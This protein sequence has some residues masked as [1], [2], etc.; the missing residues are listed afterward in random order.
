M[1]VVF[2][3]PSLY[4]CTTVERFALRPPARCGDIIAAMRDGATAIGLIDGVFETTLAVWHK[5]ILFALAS[6]IRF[7][8]ASSMGALRAAE[9]ADF[10]MEGIGAIFQDYA[11]RRRTSDADVAILH[12]PGELGYRPL[13]LSL[14]DVEFAVGVM[15]QRGVVNEKVRQEIVLKAKRLGF[16]MRTWDVLFHDVDLPSEVK[17][18]LKGCLRNTPSLKTLDALE[19]LK[20]INEPRPISSTKTIS[21][22]EFNSTALFERILQ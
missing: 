22:A 6:G 3:G 4:G 16:R 9:C 12:A 10:G 11:T 20:A 17:E 2:A 7:L 18:G 5:E 15:Q 1:N 19:L 21:F 14:V 8:G 13:T